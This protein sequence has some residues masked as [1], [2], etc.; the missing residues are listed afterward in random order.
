M[1]AYRPL[2]RA[3][4]H[5]HQSGAIKFRVVLGMA[6]GQRAVRRRM[7]AAGMFAP[8]GRLADVRD[9]MVAVRHRIA[10]MRAFWSVDNVAT[11][12]ME[13]RRVEAHGHVW[14]EAVPVA[15]ADAALTTAATER[16]AALL[17]LLEQKAAA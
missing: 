3:L 14:F 9:D 1:R 12:V 6:R 11:I 7:I 2:T 15:Q 5:L 13:R 16:G 17:D 4:P 8:A 10:E